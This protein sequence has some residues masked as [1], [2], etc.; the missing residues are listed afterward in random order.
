MH[1]RSS[2]LGAGGAREVQGWACTGQEVVTAAKEAPSPSSAVL[3]TVSRPAVHN[4]HSITDFHI[5][6]YRH[7]SL[8]VK[9][10]ESI[11][12][13]TTVLNC[14][15]LGKSGGKQGVTSRKKINTQNC[16]M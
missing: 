2:E 13:P 16:D 3:C 9:T 1:E 14:S 6:P 5:T 7:R 15:G 4:L 11:V 8:V 10:Q 12:L